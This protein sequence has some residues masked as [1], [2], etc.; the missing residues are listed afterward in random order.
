MAK[1]SCAP[2][3]KG[4][5]DLLLSKAAVLLSLLSSLAAKC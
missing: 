4:Q 5:W 2:L 3:D 1:G